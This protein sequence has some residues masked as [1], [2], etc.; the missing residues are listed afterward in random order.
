MLV[1]GLKLRGFRDIGD[2]EIK[3][4]Y[5]A[6][7]W[8][9]S[10]AFVQSIA[11]EASIFE[12]LPSGNPEYSNRTSVHHVLSENGSLE[13]KGPGA[14]AIVISYPERIELVSQRK[15]LLVFGRI[16]YRDVHSITHINRWSYLFRPGSTDE[17]D[18]WS[19]EGD[20]VFAAYR[21]YT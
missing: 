1:S 21:E 9:K 4:N 10:P 11:M 17:T 6:K 19:S 20:D 2:D 5:M 18:S 12:R 7:N 15:F 16:E 3:V 8:G 13:F 14:P